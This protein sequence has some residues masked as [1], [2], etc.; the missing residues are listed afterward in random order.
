MPF[1]AFD[2]TSTVGSAMFAYQ[3]KC[4][5]VLSLIVY[6]KVSAYL[7]KKKHC[8]FNLREIKQ[9]PLK[10]DNFFIYLFHLLVKLA[11]FHTP[12]YVSSFFA[13]LARE[14]TLAF[15]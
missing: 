9:I 3:A 1:F 10:V 12:N 2:L 5:S 15:L 14:A 4:S 6:S 11:F 13:C 8:M 7:A